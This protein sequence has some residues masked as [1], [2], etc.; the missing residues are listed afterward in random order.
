MLDRMQTALEQKLKLEFE[1]AFLEVLNE[2]HMHGGP[3][4]D[5]HFRLT[6]VS[7]RFA[8][9]SRVARHQQVYSLLSA[10]L[11]GGIHAL[12]LHLYTPGEWREREETTPRSPD[13][14]GGSRAIA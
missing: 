10:E 9:M 5:S 7:S 13:C 8:G 1:P 14:R 6:V 11:A 12:A 3:A 2:S 4:T